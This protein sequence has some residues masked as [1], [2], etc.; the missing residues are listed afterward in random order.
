M[1]VGIYL[2][3]VNIGNTKTSETNSKYVV[4]MS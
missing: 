2:F 4:L 1:I 3:K